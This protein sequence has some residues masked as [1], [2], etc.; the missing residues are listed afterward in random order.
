MVNFNSFS[1]LNEIITVFEILLF[2]FDTGLFILSWNFA[3]N[4]YVCIYR[5]KTIKVIQFTIIKSELKQLFEVKSIESNYLSEW[6]TITD[7]VFLICLY[8]LLTCHWLCISFPVFVSNKNI[9]V[10]NVEKIFL[11]F[12]LA[13]IINVISLNYNRKQKADNN[14]GWQTS[15]IQSKSLLELIKTI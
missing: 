1:R 10:N 14:S 11:Y 2:I 6:T 13:T 5:Q 9:F 3:F 15:S 4:R 12:R 8:I 7:R